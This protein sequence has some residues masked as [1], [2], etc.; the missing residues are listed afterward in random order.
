MDADFLA[1]L[2]DP[3]ESAAFFGAVQS[4]NYLAHSIREI[5][6]E[7]LR[8]K[9]EH[10]HIFTYPGKFT[11]SFKVYFYD[12]GCEIKIPADFDT[13]GKRDIRLLIAH[14]LGHIIHCFDSLPENPPKDYS[15]EAEIYSW[16]FAYH[17]IY[18][19]SQSYEERDDDEFVYTKE[20]LKNSVL[21]L[22]PQ[23][24]KR[25]GGSVEERRR[26]TDTLGQYFL[27]K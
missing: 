9:Q 4:F 18:G 10:F 20:V 13:I 15:E 26:I 3:E 14:E 7:I 23:S 2:E 22:A 21:V 6:R 17:L 19:K 8:K 24:V 27:T 1:L 16:K 25:K 11:D 5:E 12:K